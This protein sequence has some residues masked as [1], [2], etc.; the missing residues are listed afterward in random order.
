MTVNLRVIVQPVQMSGTA[1]TQ[2]TVP[3]GSRVIIDKAT[4]TN[5][6]TV[7]RNFSLNLVPSGSSASNSNLVI[8]TRT[9]IPDET[10]LCPEL[11]G[12]VLGPGDFI[13]TVASSANALSLR[14]SGREVT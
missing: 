9:V 4:V 10:Y 3:V 7:N 12:Q 1:T 11:I 13:S 6:D 5:T 2:Y 14:I 8:D